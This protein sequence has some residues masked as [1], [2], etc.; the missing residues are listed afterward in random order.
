MPLPGRWLHRRGGHPELEVVHVTLRLALLALTAAAPL[1]AQTLVVANMNDTT[2]QL[3]DVASGSVRATLPTTSVPH[4]VAVSPNG[5]WAVVTDYGAQQPG[6]TLT[7]V[8]VATGTI[9][10]TISVAPHL[11]PHGAV[12]LR[13]NRTVVVTAER[14]SVLLLVDVEAGRVTGT[15]STGQRI[16][17]MVALPRDQRSAFV[18][19]ITAGTLSIVDLVGNTEPV[20]IAVGSQT[21]GIGVTHDGRQV[22]MG[23]NNTGKVFVVDVASRRVVDSIQTAGIPYRIAFTPSD[24]LVLITNPEQDEIL[25]ID[26]A[27]RAVRR[28]VALKVESETAMGPQGI[29]I[30]P[31]G[32]RAW[33][34]M[35]T[36]N[37]VTE[38]SLPGMGTLRSWFVAPGPDGI[39]LSAVVPQ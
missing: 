21:E 1:G 34:T 9:A 23:S 5:R 27:T 26:V 30:A 29:V 19:N 6:S 8:D 11:R 39:G 36:G 14:D 3:I 4:E 28:K 37:M 33:I 18:A 31:D 10:R 20:V 12:F 32:G 13:D 16:G 15:R 17:H 7:L 25:L 24:S 35:G 22:W 38:F 2:T